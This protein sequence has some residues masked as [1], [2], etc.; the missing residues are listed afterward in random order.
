MNQTEDIKVN[1][2]VSVYDGDTLRVRINSFPNWLGDDMPCRIYGIDTP[3]IRGVS[4]EEKVLGR[5]ARDLVKSVLASAQDIRIDILGKGKYFRVIV[6]VKADGVDIGDHLISQGLA[7][8][9]DGGVK[10]PWF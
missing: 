5:Q 2:V 6:K 4:E 7:K 10:E 1:E 3:E 9:Y 8:P